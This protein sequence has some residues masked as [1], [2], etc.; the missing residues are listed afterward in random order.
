MLAELKAKYEKELAQQQKAIE[1]KYDK[2]EE[3]RIFAIVSDA[4]IE[5]LSENSKDATK[6]PAKTS[7]K[8]SSITKFPEGKEVKKTAAKKTT[9][10]K[11]SAKG[12][13][14]AS[15]AGK[16]KNPGDKS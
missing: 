5:K 14:S 7:T 12:A 4:A 10:K 8:K 1:E 16:K 15:K 13:S 11:S 9:T 3:E 2:I 6:K